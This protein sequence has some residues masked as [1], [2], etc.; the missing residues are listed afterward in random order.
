MGFLAV[1][2]F[3]FLFFPLAPVDRARG[4]SRISRI[5]SSVIFLSDRTLSRS[6]GGGAASFV[7]PFFVI[8]VR[9]S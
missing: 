2:F 7:R 8:A 4:F 3:F 5:S 6:R 1:F 9:Q